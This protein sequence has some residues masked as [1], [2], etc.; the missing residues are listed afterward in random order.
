M[1]GKAIE[2]LRLRTEESRERGSLY[3]QWFT[4]RYAEDLLRALRRPLTGEPCPASG[5]DCTHNGW[6]EGQDWCSLCG[7]SVRVTREGKLAK[8]SP[9]LK[10][11]RRGK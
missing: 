5:A 4:V 6:H 8:H 2:A 11:T 7:R 9:P 10:R 3:V 1:S